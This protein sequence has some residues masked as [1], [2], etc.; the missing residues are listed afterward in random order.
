MGNFILFFI[1]SII[2]SAIFF[3]YYTFFLKNKKI[4]GFNRFFLLAI[5]PASIVLPLIHFAFLQWQI[6]GQFLITS[7]AAIENP[8]T[9]NGYLLILCGLYALVSLALLILISYKIYSVLD[10]KQ[11]S[12]K[13]MMNGFCFLETDDDRAPFSFFNNLF[14]K[15]G[16]ST[17]SEDAGKIM[18]HEITHITSNHSYDRLFS[19]LT[20]CLFWLNPFFWWAQRELSTV[21]EFLADE[22][23]FETGDTYHFAQMLLSSYNNSSYLNP[24]LGFNKSD[25]SRRVAMIGMPKKNIHYGN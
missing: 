4:N 6:P 5:F 10:L 17:Q 14:W 8:G 23:S 11:K 15:K 3:A 22:G 19:Q 7:V 13:L 1:K 25:I 12:S 20:C 21:H 9:E 18:D 16:M 2:T 24:D